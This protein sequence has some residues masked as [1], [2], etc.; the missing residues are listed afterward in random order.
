MATRSTWRRAIPLAAVFRYGARSLAKSPLFTA[1]AVLSLGLALALNTTMF[2]LVD[3]VAHPI[4]PY[5]EPERI[6]TASF[7][8]GYDRERPITLEDRF[9]A[10]RDGSTMHEAI[11]GYTFVPALIQS[12]TVAEQQL[13]TATSPELFALL[14]V[15]PIIGRLFSASDSS[16]QTAQTAV[17]SFRLW[18]RLFA[19]Q[20]LDRGPTLHVGM[21]TYTVIGVMPR[22]VH[23]PNATDVWVPL[24]SFAA[25]TVVRKLGPFPVLRL[26]PGVTPGMAWTELSVIANRL[27]A[28][29][30]QRRPIAPRLVALRMSTPK[31]FIPPFFRPT[32]F[33]VL[34][35]ACANLGTMM[36]ARGIAR[37]RETAIRVA[38]GAGRRDVVG[39]VLAECG[40]VIAG[41][42][43]VGVLLTFWALY[44]LPHVVVPFVPELGDIDPAPSWRV[45]AF[46]LAASMAMLIGAG[47]LPAL[48]AAATDP[49][50]P[51]KEGT[52]TSTGRVRDRY[53]PL[54]VVEVALSTALLMTTALFLIIVVRLAAYEF[55]YA[56]ERLV[57]A[58][59]VVNA[60]QAADDAAVERFYDDLVARSRHL[61][62][63]REA[64][65]MRR[66][67]PDGPMV[68]VEQG[69][70]GD[71]WMNLRWY[72][73]VSPGFLRTFGIPVI[74]GRDFEPGDRA[75]GNGVVIVDEAAARRLWPDM[76]SPVGRMIK[77]GSASSRRPW[78]RVVGVARSVELQPRLDSSLPPE[79]SIYVL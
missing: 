16:R 17:I 53:N 42:M 51:M 75:S 13:V 25:D 69:K 72:H 46:V 60:R 19:G 78:L 18:N 74:Q 49:S 57:D 47:L 43:A 5:A 9:R 22:G 8:G 27:S 48:R 14:G 67:S 10:V 44:V 41:G 7:L 55:Q 63:A 26:K 39:Q 23:F 29:Y 36:L 37:R 52:G 73:V 12:G 21:A 15:R 33:M 54:I 2:A 58:T 45:F 76:P 30:A 64:A 20:S 24:A 66:D 65:T 35:I 59:I 3:A 71:Q 38:L 61:P 50:E 79:P 11:A 6:V 28:S 32:V 34:V 40:L 77:M 68:Y 56:G 4:V 62:G 31:A 1:V 70:S